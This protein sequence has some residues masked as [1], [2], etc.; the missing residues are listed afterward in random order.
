MG[1][2]ARVTWLVKYETWLPLFLNVYAIQMAIW[3][4]FRFKTISMAQL[5]SFVDLGHVVVLHRGTIQQAATFYP[6]FV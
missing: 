5:G 4:M 2:S 3:E 6:C 1:G